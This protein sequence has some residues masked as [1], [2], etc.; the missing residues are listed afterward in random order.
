MPV[1]AAAERQAAVFIKILFPLS[2]R[3]PV[4]NWTSHDAWE[5]PG[6]A[7]AELELLSI[8]GNFRGER[9]NFLGRF[10]IP[11]RSTADKELHR[12]WMDRNRRAR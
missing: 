3:G 7:G 8:M 6:E 9:S 1:P 12:H 4:Q 10:K 2:N 11:Q 5:Q